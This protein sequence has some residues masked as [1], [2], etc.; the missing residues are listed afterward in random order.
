MPWW[1]LLPDGKC[2]Q[3]LK[4]LVEGER[5]RVRVHEKEERKDERSK[6]ERKGREGGREEGR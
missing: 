3:V 2:L 1:G 5:G 4:N 6:N